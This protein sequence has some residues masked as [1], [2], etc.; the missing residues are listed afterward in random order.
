MTPILSHPIRPADLPPTRPTPVRLIPDEGQL[1]ALADRLGVDAL[2]KVR[3][4][5][6]LRSGPGR[7]WTFQGHLGATVVQPCRVTTEAVTTRIDEPVARRYAADWTPP[8][9]EETEMPEDDSVEPLRA[10]LDMGEVLEEALALAVPDFPRATGAEDLDLTAAPP[11]A[12]PL[13]DEAVKPFAGLAALKR[14]MEDGDGS[15]EDGGG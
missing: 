15:D 5:G 7:D 13:D 4:E 11:G 9:E 8:S 6:E 10:M 1:D 14:R 3:L 2:R 12:A